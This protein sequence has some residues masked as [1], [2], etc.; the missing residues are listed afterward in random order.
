MPAV[1]GISG[2]YHDAAAALVVDGVV[3]AAVQE[4][5]LSRIKND[6]RLPLHAARACLAHAGLAAGDLDRVVFYEEPVEKLERVLISTLRTFPRSL[7][8]FPRAVGAQLGGKIWVIDRIAEQLGVA[9]G[10]VG[11]TEHHRAHAASAFFVSP[12]PRAAVVTVDGVGE[13]TSTALWQ[14]DGSALHELARLEYPHSLGLLY[15]GVT[16]YLGFE[17]NEGE[18][19][20]MGLAAYGR[21]RLGD[22]F[23]RLIQLHADGTFTLGLPYFAYLADA[24]LGFGPA[25]ERLLGPRRPPHRPW[26]LD[27]PADQHYAD[28]AATLQQVTEDAMLGLAREARRRTAASAL[29]LAGGVALNAVANARLAREAGFARIFVHPA[30]GDAGGALGAAILG[31]LELGDPRPAPLATAALGLAIDVAGTAALAHELGLAVRTTGD[32]AGDVAALVAAGKIVAFCQGRFEWGPRALGQRSIL[33]NPADPDSRERLNRAIKRREP[34]RP[35]APAVLADRAAEYFVGADADGDLTPF[36]TTVCPIH[37]RHRDRL[38]AVRHVDGSARVQTVTSASA[39]EL[40]AVLAALDRTIGMPIALNT[41]LNGAGEPIIGNGTD[42]LGFLL[43]HPID[44]L[45]VGDLVI[46]RGAA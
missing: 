17:V 19:K 9:R 45:V 11:S 30:A 4:E 43:G 39:P 16:A 31:A 38:A 2:E 15:A 14:G 25:M 23:A 27:D 7:R 5:R 1:L 35:F 37:D 33:A 18:Y 24:E 41:S 6:A 20:V 32:V 26:D 46:T 21:P 28:I 10:K 8:Q 3:V 44:G 36:M 22:E 34:F 42:A 12:Y 13:A 40:A 29:C